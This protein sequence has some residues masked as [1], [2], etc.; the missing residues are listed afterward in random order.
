MLRIAK[1]VF[2]GVFRIKGKETVCH[3]VSEEDQLVTAFKGKTILLNIL[4]NNHQFQQE[5]GNEQTH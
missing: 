1:S 3:L 4:F 5:I 2:L